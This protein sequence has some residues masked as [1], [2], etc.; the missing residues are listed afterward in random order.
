MARLRHNMKV[1]HSF[2]VLSSCGAFTSS[3]SDWPVQPLGEVAPP[4]ARGARTS[5]PG[6][7]AAELFL[8]TSAGGR[9]CEALL[10]CAPL[11]AS[12][13]PPLGASATG[14]AAGGDPNDGDGDDSSSSHSTDLSEEQE[15]EGWVA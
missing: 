13:A 11:E 9:F 4:P 5:A 12:P 7:G 15:S 1:S 3:S 6:A 10:P 14:V 8:P 2:L